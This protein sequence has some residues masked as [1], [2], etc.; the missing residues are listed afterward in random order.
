MRD[1]TLQEIIA[2]HSNSL[3]THAEKHLLTICY[4]LLLGVGPRMPERLAGALRWPR[5]K[6]EAFLQS[7]G[8]VV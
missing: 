1:V 6:A 2:A 4:L 8:V 5:P 3:A 7:T